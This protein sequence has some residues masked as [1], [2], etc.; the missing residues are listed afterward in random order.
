MLSFV[1][2]FLFS[3][4][5]RF[6]QIGSKLGDIWVWLHSAS[7]DSEE[8][9]RSQPQLF[10]LRRPFGS[11]HSRVFECVWSFGVE[12]QMSHPGDYELLSY[13]E[14]RPGPSSSG[15]MQLQRV[16]RRDEATLSSARSQSPNGPSGIE[17]QTSMG[18]SAVHSTGTCQ[19]CVFN[20]FLLGCRQADTCGYCHLPQ[21]PNGD[22]DSGSGATRADPTANPRTSQ[23]LPWDWRAT[24]DTA[25]RSTS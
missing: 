23:Q 20:S 15:G 13:P 22:P 4:Y 12:P 21:R 10:V 24:W 19:P 18:E 6:N 14:A 9:E 25:S 11:G 1:E 16:R 3:K 8:K 17:S 5:M 2:R 7:W